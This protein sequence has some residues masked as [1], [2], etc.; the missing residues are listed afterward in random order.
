[1]LLAPACTN[2]TTDL[3]VPVAIEIEAPA[4]LSLEEHDTLRLVVRVFDRGGDSLPGAPI[5]LAVIDTALLALD[6]ADQAVVGRVP[7]TNARVVALSGRLRSDPLALVVLARADS[8]GP[9]G[10]TADTLAATDTASAPLS[11]TLL[12]LHTVPGTPTPLGGRT[13]TFAIVAPTFASLDSAT[14]VLG[15]DSLAARATTSAAGVASV[16]VKRKGAAQPDSVVVQAT[17]HRASGAVIAGSPV[18]FVV[19]FP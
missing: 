11:V 18:Q 13:V 16:I 2:L 8:I 14:A 15:N 19:R 9:V 5:A 4:S 17:A 12:D 3:T 7:G 10:A 1:V 6:S